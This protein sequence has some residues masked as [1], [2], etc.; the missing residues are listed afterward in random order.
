MGDIKKS[1]NSTYEIDKT[2]TVP[3]AY[4]EMCMTRNH[5]TVTALVIGWAVSIV[6]VV[7]AFVVL[8]LQ[9]D[10]VAVDNTTGVYVLSDSEGNV[11]ASDLEPDDVIHIMELLKDGEYNQDTSS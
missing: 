6:L 9:Y 10:Y 2:A 4:H 7:I 8:W 3:L 11:I 5:K 1:D